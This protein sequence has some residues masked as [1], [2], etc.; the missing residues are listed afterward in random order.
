MQAS[1]HQVQANVYHRVQAN[2]RQVQANNPQLQANQHQG[3]PRDF[4]ENASPR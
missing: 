2:H 1:G 4:T 3:Q